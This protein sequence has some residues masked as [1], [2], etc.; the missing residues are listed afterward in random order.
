MS[1][2]RPL[3]VA[4]KYNGFQVELKLLHQNKKDFTGTEQL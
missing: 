1:L 2:T 4:G 3:A